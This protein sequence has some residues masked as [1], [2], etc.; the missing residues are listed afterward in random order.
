MVLVAAWPPKHL[1]VSGAKTDG[2]GHKSGN[3]LDPSM[4]RNA[5]LVPLRD[6]TLASFFDLDLLKK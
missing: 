4:Y 1:A 6:G 5:R 3:P 2:A